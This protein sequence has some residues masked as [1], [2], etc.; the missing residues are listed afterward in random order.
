MT[1]GLSHAGS[2]A[3]AAVDVI[4]WLVFSVVTAAG[5]MFDSNLGGGRREVL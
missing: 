2:G 5:I 1:T 4:V 3:P